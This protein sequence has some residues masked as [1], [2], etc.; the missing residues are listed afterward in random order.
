MKTYRTKIKCLNNS[1]DQQQRTAQSPEETNEINT[2]RRTDRSRS[3]VARFEGEAFSP[4]QSRICQ[5]K[6]KPEEVNK[7]EFFQRPVPVRQGKQTCQS[8]YMWRH[9]RMLREITMAIC[10][11]KG[12]SVQPKARVLVFKLEPN[13]GVE[14]PLAWILRGGGY[15]V[16]GMTMKFQPISPNRTGILKS[17]KTEE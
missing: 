6:T 8:R 12:L 3:T 11:A 2:C 4:K 9:K 17:A 1:K 10:D 14:G 7:K 13:L 5:E 15:W 16:G